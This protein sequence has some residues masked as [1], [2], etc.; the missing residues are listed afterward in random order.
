MSRF[1]LVPIENETRWLSS[2]PLDLGALL[3]PSWEKLPAAVRRRFARAHTT[4]IYDGSIEL[5]C[6]AIGFVFAT[7][8]RLIGG[9]L[10]TLSGTDIPATVSVSADGAGGVIWERAFHGA[11]EADKRA[12]VR[13]RSTKLIG[14][15]GQLVEQTDGGIG[16]QL[17]AFEDNGVLVFQSR[18]Y[19][20]KI[21]QT[22]IR[23]PALLTPGVCR[24]EHRDLGAG[25]FRFS[26]TMQ[27]PLY[28][29]T[30][31]QSGIFCD[32]MGEMR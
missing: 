10:T 14:P 30:F 7:L 18:H 31:F 5:R 17:D 27:H 1:T 9:P 12:P 3:G 22:R 26:M 6:S 15:N 4:T 23:I 24:V 8:S 25:R 20:W 21:G 19:F 2:P 32:P 28:G 11:V 13:V 16:M 29:T